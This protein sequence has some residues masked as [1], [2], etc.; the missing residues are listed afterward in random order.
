MFIAYD[1]KRTRF[2]FSRKKQTERRNCFSII[3]GYITA[4]E[5][6]HVNNVKFHF[7]LYF[8][9]IF[10]VAYKAGCISKY[11]CIKRTTP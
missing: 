5:K 10:I 1:K 4:R 6:L 3:Y 2:I 11:R 8:A 7:A 9:S